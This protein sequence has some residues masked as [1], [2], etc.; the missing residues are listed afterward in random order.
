MKKIVMAL[1]ALVALTLAV[2]PAAFATDC[3]TRICELATQ[4]EYVTKASC[5]VYERTAVVAIKTEKFTTKSQYETFVKELT[6]KIKSE[7]EVDHVFV[8]RNPKIMRQIE[9]LS[10]MDDEQRDEALQKILEELLRFRPIRK[11][12]ITKIKDV[13]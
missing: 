9:E 13:K 8:T 4:N 2:A 1:L 5:V 11:I 3:E 7:C 6:T 12:D 10:E